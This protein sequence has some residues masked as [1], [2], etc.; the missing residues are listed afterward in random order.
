MKYLKNLTLLST[1]FVG[2]AHLSGCG[3]TGPLYLPGDKP[4]ASLTVCSPLP[5][6]PPAA[7]HCSA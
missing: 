6:S 3:Q 2:L 5:F 7:S 4:A 1:V